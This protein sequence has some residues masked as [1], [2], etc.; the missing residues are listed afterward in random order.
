MFNL[1]LTNSSDPGLPAE[2]DRSN[3]SD[4]NARPA[5]PSSRLW[6][7]ERYLFFLRRKWWILALSLFIFCAIGMAY[8][9]W[10]PQSYATTA[11]LWMPQTIKV[12]DAATYEDQSQAQGIGPTQAE[13]LASDLLQN[14]AFDILRASGVP[15]PSNSEGKPVPAKL[16]VTQIA[17]TS[18]L[19]IAAR[20]PGALYVQS[21]LNASMDALIAYLSE[22]YDQQSTI[23]YSSLNAQIAV[24]EAELKTEQNK[25]TAYMRTNNVPVLEDSAKAASARLS[26]ML[27]EYSRTSLQYRLLKAACSDSSDSF[28][29]IG[30][31]DI[32]AP[33]GLGSNL[34]GPAP[35]GLGIPSSSYAE[36]QRRMTQLKLQRDSFSKYFRPDHPKMVKLN[37]EISQLEG[38]CKSLI[39]QNHE[40]LLASMNL[41]KLKMTNIQESVKEWEE[42]VNDASERIADFERV[43]LEVD[44]MRSFYDHLVLLLQNVDVSR[45]LPRIS[46]NILDRA[47]PAKPVKLPAKLVLGA[48]AFGG[49]F[50]GLVLIRAM[51][52]FNDDVT[53][54]DY[55]AVHFGERIVGHIPES[56]KSCKKEILSNMEMDD[57]GDL[58]AESYRSI[59]SN[60][61]FG[62]RGAA[63]PRVLLVTSSAPKE[64]KSTVALNVACTLASGGSRVVLID[65]DLRL[66]HLHE[67]L[68]MKREPGLTDLLQHPED[69]DR[70]LQTNCRPNL[71]FVSRGWAVSRP[72]DLFVGPAVELLF[73]RLRQ[74][75]DFIVI[76]SVPI[77]AAD[78]TL[79]LAARTDGVIFVVR[80]SFTS[81][82]AA[83]QA[84]RALYARQVTVLGLV[85]NRVARE[86]AFSYYYP[87]YYG[88]GRTLD[89]KG[90]AVSR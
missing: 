59:R 89:L 82:A 75:F 58:F 74:K 71:S 45:N 78:D 49:L 55:L 8:N 76:D 11:R 87:E 1:K 41:A 34:V 15:I 65:A 7:V 3:T 32:G 90:A 29:F 80:D 10:Y 20:G 12:A 40:Q 81:A 48:A 70:I 64:G 23:T 18:V 73:E 42:K 30:V 67:T 16:R 28:K 68:G 6:Q 2:L 86:R 51:E 85:F 83:K 88:Q 66:G 17:R 56:P 39:S 33:T 27:A 22:T 19:E 9:R 79:S 61:L 38:L 13:L 26:E 53:S 44:R 35:T 69:L 43:K 60:L 57:P 72:G 21:F 36:A 54:L 77:L 47:S 84:L 46:I 14:R 63:T 4:D 24:K 50:F 25:L 37:E 52:F 31:S 5:D 62:K